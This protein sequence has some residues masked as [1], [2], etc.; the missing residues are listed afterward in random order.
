MKYIHFPE[1]DAKLSHPVNYSHSH[2]AVKLM[3]A[4][5][6]CLFIYSQFKLH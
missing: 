6:Q 4:S 3:Y 2:S 5:N 1:G